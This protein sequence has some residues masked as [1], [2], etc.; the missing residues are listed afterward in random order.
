MKKSNPKPQAMVMLPL[1]LVDDVLLACLYAELYL[2]ITFE[3]ANEKPDDYLEEDINSMKKEFD[4][5]KRLEEKFINL[6]N[7]IYR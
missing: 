7:E 5:V 4:R 6:N 2:N 3:C 1:E